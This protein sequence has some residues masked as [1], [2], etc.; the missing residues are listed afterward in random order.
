MGEHFSCVFVLVKQ[1]IQNSS[2]DSALST[3]ESYGQWCLVPFFWLMNVG[4]FKQIQI[5]RDSECIILYYKWSQFVVRPGGIA[6]IYVNRHISNCELVYT[7]VS[8]T[9]K[10]RFMF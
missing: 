7:F 5:I 10:A 4:F 8:K 9:K 2:Y 6:L 3:Q 1:Y